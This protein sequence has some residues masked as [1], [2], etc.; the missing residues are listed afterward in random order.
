MNALVT[1]WTA[2]ILVA[3]CAACLLRIALGPQAADRL[4]ALA[5]LSSLLLALL[6]LFGSAEGRVLYLDVAL[7][8]D[9]V[10]FLGILAVASLIKD[11]GSGKGKEEE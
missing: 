1:T 8:Y 4:T 5:T 11:V 2:R 7:V 9:V 6:V 3:C 10:G